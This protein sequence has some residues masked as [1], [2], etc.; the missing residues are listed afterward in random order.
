LLLTE[1]FASITVSAL[2]APFAC[3]NGDGTIMRISIAVVAAMVLLLASSVASAR[4]IPAA[5]VTVEDV[6]I[7]LQNEGHT[8]QVVTSS[9][10]KRHIKT[11]TAGVEFSVYLF[12][13][14]EGRCGSIQ[15]A[16]GF[17]T[18]GKF[19]ISRLNE[20]NTKKRWGRAYHDNSN[21]PWVEMDVDLT[22][23]GTYELLHDE[24]MTWNKTLAD[25]VTMFGLK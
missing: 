19:D 12:D 2:H 14:T 4:D 8:T 16:A 3:G 17:A 5:G 11:S 10:G 7:W 21:D 20:W 15:F 23:G 1:G 18:H 22:P 25:F 24:L 9:D 6:V 13:C